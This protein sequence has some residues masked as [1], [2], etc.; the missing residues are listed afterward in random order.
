MKFNKL[1][2]QPFWKSNVDLGNSCS[3]HVLVQR[4]INGDNS[5]YNE[6]VENDNSK[7]HNHYNFFIFTI[8]VAIK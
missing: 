2:F 6:P 3:T 8:I 7:F 5:I 1:Q 4:L